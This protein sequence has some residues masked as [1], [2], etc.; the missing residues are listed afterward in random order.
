MQQLILYLILLSTSACLLKKRAS[1]D[2]FIAFE[3]QNF[4]KLDTLIKKVHDDD[5]RWLVHYSY[6][7]NCPAE[8]KN[9]GAALTAAISTALQTWLRPLRD[10][11]KK[12]LIADFRYKLSAD[13]NAADLGVIFHCHIGA[14]TAFVTVGET[15]G[16][17]MRSDVQVNR[18]FMSALVHEM[19]HVFGLADTYLLQKEMGRGLD[20]GGM[21]DTKGAQPASVMA[22]NM[23]LFAGARRDDELRQPL[24]LGVDDI[25]GIVWL[26]KHIHEGQPLKDCFFPNYEFE[27]FPAGCRPQHP[28]IFELKYGSTINNAREVHALM[29]IAED[30]QLAVNVQDAKGMT[31]LHY[32]VSN[33][34]AKVVE[35][36]IKRDDI[37]P[38]LKNKK[39]QSPLQL[40]QK[41]QR[42]DLAR[43]IRAHPQA[44]SVNAKGKAAV[45]WGELK[46][47]DR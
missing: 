15:P 31:A 44:L 34:Y 21:D 27:D 18:N 13:W 37:K 1:S 11:T 26:Y 16:I 9:N 33:G 30:E 43:L 32:A 40:A 20:T 47:G 7:D 41:L 24:P 8:K 3:H 39:G 46:R 19:G 14:D 38:F 25:N 4:M 45:T 12:P 10:Y 42:D 17:N 36:L 28:L 35:A 29:I 23:P 5:K 2:K 22:A 6:G